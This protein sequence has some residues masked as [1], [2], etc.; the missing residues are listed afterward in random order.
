MSEVWNEWQ[1]LAE[2]KKGWWGDRAPQMAKMERSRKKEGEEEG[3]VT[4]ALWTNVQ[5]QGKIGLLN[6]AN[7]SWKADKNNKFQK[8]N[9]SVFA[10]TN[11]AYK[12]KQH[13][14]TCPDEVGSVLAIYDVHAFCRK[15]GIWI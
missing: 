2:N 1:E 10:P 3:N 9:Q 13:K 6:S 14:F 4:L 11:W 15:H 7:A 12:T 5:Q 8:C